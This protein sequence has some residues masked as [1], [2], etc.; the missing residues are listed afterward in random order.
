M[1]IKVAQFPNSI[2]YIIMGKR[3]WQNKGRMD[4]GLFGCKFMTMELEH[5]VENEVHLKVAMF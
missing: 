5:I 4:E 2:L 3:K 1:N